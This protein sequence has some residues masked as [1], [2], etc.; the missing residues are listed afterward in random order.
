MIGAVLAHRLP[1]NYLRVMVTIS[2]G[3]RPLMR[4][5]DFEPKTFSS[6]LAGLSSSEAAREINYILACG[7]TAQPMLCLVKKKET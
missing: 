1:G 5:E 3:A 6:H 4:P 7:L 2:R